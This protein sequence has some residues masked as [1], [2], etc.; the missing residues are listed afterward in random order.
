LNSTCVT[1]ESRLDTKSLGVRCTKFATTSEAYVGST[2]PCD[3]GENHVGARQIFPILSHGK[4][5]TSTVKHHCARTALAASL[6]ACSNKVT[7][8]PK[9]MS[10]YRRFFH[11]TIIPMFMKALDAESVNVNIDEWLK[12]YDMNYRRSIYEGIKPQNIDISRKTETY[13]AFA[14]IEQQFTEVL[15]DEKDT[16]LNDVKERQICGPTA[17]KKSVNAFI[18]VLE[19]VAHRHVK[20]YCGRKNW[21]DICKDFETAFNIPSALFGAADGSGFDMTQLL[22]HNELMNE[23]I[24][25]CARHPNVSWDEPLNPDLMQKF[26]EDSLVLNVK[27]PTLLHYQVQGRASGDGWTT[28]G[29]TVLMMSYWMFCFEEAN[30]TNYFLRVKGDDV[31]FALEDKQKDQLEQA[32]NSLFTMTKDQQSWGLGQICK[33]VNYGSLYEL[34]FLSNHFFETGKEKLRMTRIPARVIQSLSWTTKIPK[35]IP[36]EAALR[37]RRELCYSKGMCLKAW[38]EGLPL[39]SVLADKMIELGKTGKMSEFNKY[40][41]GD[42]VW[43]KRDDADAYRHYLEMRYALSASDVVEIE[44]AIRGIKSLDGVVEIPLLDK[45]YEP[46]Y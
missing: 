45:L 17:Y 18:N 23:L 10:R 31:V 32:K 25:L 22:E 36:K 41:D 33:K 44:N 43:H 12:E 35:N 8:D 3:A 38:A 37:M 14:K 28:F 42:R 2:I 13:E 30:I 20:Q 6:R 15:H 9:V 5:R 16:S 11:E 4:F 40:A 29:N 24:M 1:D 7:P 26:L 46:L 21:I 27:V 19:G 34:D 39:W